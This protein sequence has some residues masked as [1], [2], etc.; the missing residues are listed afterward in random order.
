[1]KTKT[2][3]ISSTFPATPDEIWTRITLF[4]TLCYIAAPYAYF[5][6]IGSNAELMWSEGKTTRFHLKIFG[7]FP[8][9]IHSI[10]IIEFNK[11]NY[12]IFS[13]EE[14]RSVPI[15]NHTIILRPAGNGT[16]YYE[17]I[18]EIGAG[19]KTNLVCAWSKMFYRLRQKRWCKLL[20]TRLQ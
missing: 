17:D 18:V 7:V 1:M 13:N 11:E 4:E 19:W 14:N 16:T 12:R 20:M 2:T 15:W 5:T 9:G 6:A 8:M 3:S 10:K